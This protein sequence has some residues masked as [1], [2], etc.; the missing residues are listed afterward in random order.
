M[1]IKK[2]TPK[3]QG[4]AAFGMRLRR[5]S[6]QLDWQGESLSPTRGHAFEPRWFPVIVLIS[7]HGPLSVGELAFLIGIT[8]AAV[9][10]VRGELI[11]QRILRGKTDPA[12]RR[13]QILELTKKGEKLS[14]KLQPL[15][16][17]V[18]AAIQALWKEVAPGFPR[19]LDRIE[20]ALRRTPMDVRA[21]K[22]LARRKD[23]RSRQ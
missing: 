14:R 9:S 7:E 8:H 23:G 11:R 21:R 1:Q 6:E 4:A 17:A 22:F 2:N 20:A 15:Q 16:S 19:Q 10:Q 5:L 13:R 12:D 3:Q 18:A